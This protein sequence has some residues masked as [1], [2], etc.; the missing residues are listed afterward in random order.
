MLRI[1][2]FGESIESPDIH[3]VAKRILELVIE[4]DR[5]QLVNLGFVWPLIIAGSMVSE[6]GGRDQARLAL[7]TLRFVIVSRS[8]TLCRLTP[9]S[10]LRNRNFYL[11]DFN[12]AVDIL[13]EVIHLF[14]PSP[15][16]VWGSPD[17][18][19]FFTGLG[20][21]GCRR[22]QNNL[23]RCDD[24][25]RGNSYHLTSGR[26]SL[27]RPVRI[28][29]LGRIEEKTVRRLGRWRFDQHLYTFETSAE[30]LL[31]RVSC[32]YMTCAFISSCRVRRLR[33]SLLGF[34]H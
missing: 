30:L 26:S 5:R 10:F 33:A 28:P 12:A 21:Q 7:Q 3:A 15:A 4:S 27:A 25:K 17:M 1:E 2:V 20:V 34:S 14:G 19:F 11:F 23:A 8:S 16:L 18:A 24:Q 6:E 29:L 9:P 31:S 32:S 22:H 13:H